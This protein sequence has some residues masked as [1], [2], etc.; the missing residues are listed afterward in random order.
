MFLLGQAY[1]SRQETKKLSGSYAR[2]IN[3]EVMVK[4]AYF[5]IWILP[6]KQCSKTTLLSH[7]RTCI[8]TF[9]HLQWR[10][11]TNL[12]P[13]FSALRFFFFE[14]VVNAS[15][16]LEINVFLL[17]SVLAWPF[18]PPRTVQ[19]FGMTYIR[20]LIFFCEV[21]WSEADSAASL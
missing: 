15:Y 9:R 21:T 13:S 1:L 2:S 16:L 19:L 8:H 11:E 4:M 12:A 14:I 3:F 5:P 17:R 6:A 18:L 10:V 7:R 20:L